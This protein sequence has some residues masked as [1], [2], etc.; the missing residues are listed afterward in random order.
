MEIFFIFKFFERKK[1]E[2]KKR[3]SDE[4]EAELQNDLDEI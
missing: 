2:E 1:E 4:I 3:K